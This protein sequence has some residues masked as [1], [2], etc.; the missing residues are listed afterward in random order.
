MILGNRFV[1]R[2]GEIDKF[3]AILARPFDRSGGVLLIS[4]RAGIGKTSLARE[5]HAIAQDRGALSLWAHFP[6]QADCPPY[7]GWIGI[8]RTLDKL[9]PEAN[10][11]ALAEVMSRPRE[12][13]P[14]SMRMSYLQGLC[15][16]ISSLPNRQRLVL[17]FDDVQHADRGSAALLEAIVAE[18]HRL[19]VIIVSTFRDGDSQPSVV[20]SRAIPHLASVPHAERI[21]LRGIDELEC[22]Q[23]C[24][25][26]SGW[27]P[28]TGITRRLHRQTEGNPLFIK[29]IVQTLVDQG[30]IK[31]GIANIPSR[32]TVPEGMSEAI[33]TLFDRAT[34]K[35]QGT[36]E[37]AAILGRR[38]DLQVLERVAPDFEHSLLDEAAK[39]GLVE[40]VDSAL[41][42]W[43]FCHAL[44]REVLYDRVQPMQRVRAHADAASA[45]EAVYG[46]DNRDTLPALAYHAFEGQL[47]FGARRVIELARRSARHAMELAAYE[48]AARQYRLALE[49]FGV[50]GVKDKLGQIDVALE[51]ALAEQLSG[52][53]VASIRTCREAIRKARNLGDWPRF[54]RAALQYEAARWQP[55]LP[56]N[57]VIDLLKIAMEHCEELSRADVARIHYSLARAYQWQAALK[58]AEEHALKSIEIARELEDQSLLCE[59]IDQGGSA[60]HAI[61]GTSALRIELNAEGLEIARSRD[62][63]QRLAYLLVNAGVIHCEAGNI[64]QFREV[65]AELS[66]MVREMAQ[67]HLHYVVQ[68]WTTTIAMLGGDFAGAATSAAAAQHMGRRISG[69]DGAGIYGIQMFMINRERGVLDELGDLAREIGRAEGAALWRPGYALLL[70]EA[71]RKEDAATALREFMCDGLDS[72]P[73]DDLR[74]LTLAF[75]AEVSWLTRDSVAAVQILRKLEGDSGMVATCGPAAVCFGPV[76]RSLGNLEACLQRF[77]K[78]RSY[79]ESALEETRA[80]NSPPTLLRTACDFCEVLLLD[81]SPS[82]IKRARE[83][84]TEFAKNAAAAGM[85]SL[86]RRFAAISEALRELA[87]YHG[88]DVLTAREVEVLR[89]LAKG[90]SNAE[91]SEELGI[92]MATTA[93]HVRNI[94]SK[95]NCRNRTAAA[96]FARQSGLAGP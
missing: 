61:P 8:C 36:L 10:A 22:V 45:I 9:L 91:I 64:P 96:G 44:I 93:T 19:P 70:A 76:N 48:D 88:F 84:Q 77:E 3:E 89:V 15:D 86:V 79:F 4:G 68:H 2:R 57:E 66:G 54:A 92:S 69:A 58:L 1:G 5:F 55:G 83:L 25:E 95:T 33:L 23:L 32:L 46:P 90:A 12:L 72:L 73:V 81:G 43:Q 67:P 52:E 56:S 75:L 21:V 26:L 31:D 74:R 29:Q 50:P 30:H 80:W 87:A 24:R 63:K 27:V 62:D 41:G 82:A 17:F 49:C 85:R 65:Y 59:A 60:L 6:E 78:A 42:H 71:G 28:D 35:C 20:G 39:I 40:P 7:W 34:I 53:N 47:F 16:I 51:L 11:G 14:G 94:L 13:Q 38:F 18:V 37:R